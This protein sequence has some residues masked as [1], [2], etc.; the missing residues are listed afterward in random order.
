MKPA[1]SFMK[2]A[3]FF[4]VFERTGTSGFFLILEFLKELELGGAL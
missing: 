3:G 1:G 4:K 2:T